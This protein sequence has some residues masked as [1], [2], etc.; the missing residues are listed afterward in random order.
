MSI[1]TVKNVLYIGEYYEDYTRNY[2]FINGLKQNQVNVYEI[3][4]NKMNKTKRIEVLLSNFKKL[5]NIDFDVLIF[6]SIKTSPINFILAR[7][8]AYFK[9]I[10]F[11]HDV[12]ISKHLTYY[13][14]RNLSIVK[15]KIKLKPY[16]WIYYYLL[17]FFECH[18]SSYVLLDTFSHINYFHKKYNIPTKKFRR[19][20]VGVR[21]DIYFPIDIKEK[22]IDKFIVGYWGTFIPLHGIEFMIQA[23]ELLKKESDIYLT[24]LGTGQTYDSDKELAERLKI[25]NIEFIP[26]MFI[27]SKELTK[28]PEFI[29]KFDLGLGIFGIGEKTLLSIPNKVYEGIAMKIPMINCESPAIRELFKENEN[30]ILC[31]PGDPKALAEA[32]LKL[33]NDRDLQLKIKENAYE[34]FENYC[35]IDK[36][37]KSIKYFLN[38]IL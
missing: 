38:N 29:A 3:N 31:K 20:L 27:T 12:F 15:K 24:L 9:R 18:F 33:K 17:D 30:I 35:T 19:I 14:D 32:I 21:D 23:F 25:K 26:K 11:I 34:I 7:A 6:F 16:Y 4:L 8:F 13:Y 10:P 36:I 1:K 28:L 2:I 5:Q 22:N 37:G